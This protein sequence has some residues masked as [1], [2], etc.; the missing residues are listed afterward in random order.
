MDY[1]GNIY[2]VGEHYERGKSI[3]HHVE[4]IMALADK[5]GWHRDSKGRLNAL[6]DSAATQRTLASEKSVAELFYEKGILVNTNVKK[7]LYSGIQRVKSL[8]CQNPPKLY[9]FKTCTNMISELKSYWWGHDDRPK[10]VDD[11]AMDDL[12]YFVMSLPDP[13]KEQKY[14]PSVIEA[15]KEKLIRFNRRNQW[16]KNS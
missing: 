4:K 13:A 5:L 8:L 16:M 15:D 3:D 2:V 6:I 1:D 10:K 9:I 14:T 7:D 11:H 12:R